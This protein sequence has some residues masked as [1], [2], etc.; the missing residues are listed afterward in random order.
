MKPFAYTRPDTLAETTQIL[1]DD[2][3]TLI[4]G[5]TNLVDLMKL[6][7]ETPARLADIN[8]IGFAE[9]ADLDDGGLSIGA[10]A[11]NT[12]TAVHERVRADFPVLAR[13]IL[14]G[15]SQQ[16]RNRATT[17]GNLCQRTRCYYFTNIDQPC[18]KR[19]PGSGCGAIDGVAK[20]HAVLGTSDQCTATYPG[21]MAVALSALDAQVQIATV[22]GESR[23]VPVR[24]FHCLPGDTPWIDNVLE[25]GE[26]ITAVTLPPPVGG[27]QIYRKV[28]ERSSYAFA[29]V[30]IA[31][32]IGL[33]D[34]V[35]ERAD[36]AFGGLAHKPWHDPRI[37]E[38]L[39]GNAPSAG[40]FDKAA[41][42][43]LEG[44]RGFGENDFK[45]PLA[46]RTLHAVL[47]QATEK[48]A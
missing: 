13:A 5:G 4:A 7:V 20:L 34:G 35:F 21:D 29:L 12:A 32:I 43:L 37:A 2:A 8:R 24:D 31:A 33:K 42:I 26:V 16:L 45:I 9:I 23:T 25:P 41:D 17:G 14:A 18:N 40:L 22:D 44:A 38:A 46:R 6:Q 36:L 11:T 27:T 1:G 48:A 39:V 47:E 15:A 3:A 19:E 28:R 30:S 10:L